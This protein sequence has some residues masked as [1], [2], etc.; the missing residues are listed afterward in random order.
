MRACTDDVAARWCHDEQMWRL[1]IVDDH[2]SFR[3]WARELLA[4]DGSTETVALLTKMIVRLGHTRGA[5]IV[6]EGVEDEEQ[7]RAI[8]RAGCDRVQGFFK[9][10][11]MPLDSL[12]RFIASKVKS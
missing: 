5:E 1:L 12:T 9:G 6:A 10:L 7:M 2:Q 8:R 3:S 11:P 4:T